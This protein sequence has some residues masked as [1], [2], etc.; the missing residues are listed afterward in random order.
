M[1]TPRGYVVEH[2]KT[3]VRYA[4]SP[5]NFNPTV[6]DKVRELK[7]GE[8]PSAYRPRTKEKVVTTVVTANESTAPVNPVGT[9]K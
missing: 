1:K 3:R 8:T 2:K 9:A 5:A 4:V 7:P 6:H